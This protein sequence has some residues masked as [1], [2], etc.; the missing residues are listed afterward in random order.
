MKRRPS[1]PAGAG[2]R[3][4]APPKIAGR[5][6][7]LVGYM[8]AGKSTVG[9][10]LA[11]RLN[12]AF[13]DLDDRI[14]LCEGRSVAEIFRHSGEAGFRR[15]EEAALQQALREAREGSAKV[16]AL[17]G[18][19]FVPPANAARLKA[20]GVPTVFLDAPVEELWQRCQK[21]VSELDAVRPLLE[22]REGFGELYQTRLPSYLKAALRVDT[23]G[24]R[25]EEV[26]E[27]IVNVLDLEEKRP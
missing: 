6:V 5:A 13:E 22:T 3:S 14:E 18:G 1:K 16:I 4:A 9:R 8:G 11:R 12:W 10:V 20:A 15:A 2:E 7:F 27:Q 23:S 25:V 19:A 21:Q 17:G 24:L 26:A